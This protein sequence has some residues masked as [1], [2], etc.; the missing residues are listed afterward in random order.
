MKTVIPL[1]HRTEHINMF[2]ICLNGVLFISFISRKYTSQPIK[3]SIVIPSYPSMNCTGH[4]ELLAIV[5]GKKRFVN[6]S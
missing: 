6:C 4:K 3:H 2:Y 1:G 5:T